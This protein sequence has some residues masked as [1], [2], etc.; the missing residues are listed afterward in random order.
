MARP[1][2]RSSLLGGRL[3]E[4]WR[5][6]F[7]LLAA[8][9][10]TSCSSSTDQ[11]GLPSPR[12]TNSATTNET[13]INV[14]VRG[15]DEGDGT[16][17]RPLRSI[18]AA[19]EKSEAGGVILVHGGVYHEQ[20]KIEDRDGL[21]IRAAPG[22]KVWLDGSRVVTGW[23]RDGSIWISSGWRAKFD[24]SP[25]FRWGAPDNKRPAWRFINPAHP[26][27][28]YPDQVW[29]EGKR[30]KQVASKAEVRSGT[31]Y[32]DYATS[33][34]YLG[35]DPR[36]RTVRASSLA[37]ALRIRSRGTAIMG[38]GIRNYAPS[39]PH[40][41]AVTVEASGVTL[42]DLSILNSATSGLHIAAADTKIQDVTVAQSGMLGIGATDADRLELSNV[43][44]RGNNVERFNQSP[45]AGGVKIGR[46]KG[47]IVR[48]SDF[49]N[50]QGPG[51][52]FDESTYNLGVFHSSAFHNAGD[53]I[54][55]ELSGKA[56]IVNNVVADNGGNGIMIND[57]DDV[58]LWNNTIVR[59]RRLIN[60]AQDDRDLDPQGSF[61]DRSLPLSWQIHDIVIRNNI[62]DD[63]TGDCL[64][65][66]ED[67]TGRIN[68]P[69]LDIALGGNVLHRRDSRFP[70][71]LIVWASGHRDPY[72]FSSLAEF[73]RTLGR[74]DPGVL[75]TGDRV[76]T[77][78]LE[79][80]RTVLQLVE[81]IAAPLPVS[82]A[83]RA[84]V[85]SQKKYLGAWGR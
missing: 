13:V 68:A 62:L 17:A 18:G 33:K 70:R 53:G 75:V 81:S 26:M 24:H 39:V 50:N 34:L 80:Q 41:G 48:N 55:V 84:G 5:P 6:M 37:Q 31:F 69:D 64:L 30:Q 78:A 3:R 76:V 20:L 29:V 71:R 44:V 11:D 9:A 51:L 61:R 10:L 59:N 58:Q 46:A 57:S 54:R 82:L 7:L 1:A 8:L 56:D 35:Q 23:T 28:A 22:A 45:A 85:P 4:S 40:M 21:T 43:V 79:P 47:V 2:H 60:I 14:A 52:W 67:F 49:E 74:E 19:L 66:V 65:C 25:T 32:V 27:A 72:A 42:E 16:S 73:G 77:P 12:P 63:S 83:S 15:S 36:G 38:I